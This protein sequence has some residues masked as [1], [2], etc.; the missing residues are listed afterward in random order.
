MVP[1]EMISKAGVKGINHNGRSDVLLDSPLTINNLRKELE[2]EKNLS[3]S[4]GL[5][6][7]QKRHE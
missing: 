4:L 5:D 2:E 3:K 1:L 7:D 6:L